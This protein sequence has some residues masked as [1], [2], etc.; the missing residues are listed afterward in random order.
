MPD[1][2]KHYDRYLLAGAGLATALVA[3]WVALASGS[4]KEAASLPPAATGGEPFAAAGDVEALKGD[5]AVMTAGRSWRESTNG[6]SPFVSRIYLLKDDRLVDILES[7]NDLFPPIP[8]AWILQHDL[9]YSDASLPERDPDQDNF[10]NLEEF[11][12]KTNPRNSASKPPL[13]TKL[14]LKDVKIE[15]LRFTFTS[16]PTGSADKVAINTIS[17]DNPLALSGAT[18]IYPRSS[19]K[20][21]TTDGEKNVD[22]RILLLAERT[23]D[24][25][26]VFQITPFR[27][28]RVELTKRFNPSTNAEEEAPEAIILNTADEKVI[29]LE[30]NKVKDSPYP[31]ATFLDTRNGSS[32]VLKLGD[33]LDFGP[34]E[35]YKLV[36][37]TL[38]EAKI[39]DLATTEQHPIPKAA[40]AAEQP[41]IPEAEQPQ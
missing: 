1:L 40:P 8:N 25:R 21:R 2:K 6:A 24:G 34:E 5:R 31:L 4:L 18:Q 20:V 3:A 30:L 14:R 23:S 15:K 22:E 13:W 35:T 39:Q 19:K 38:E 26:Q 7:G 10:T 28:E 11:A 17:L 12:S 27:F 37:V 33:A 32:R 16:L 36:D 41:L 9:D 29:R